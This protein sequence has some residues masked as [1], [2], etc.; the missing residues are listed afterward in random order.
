M[1]E[2]WSSVGGW[3]SLLHSWGVAGRDGCAAN[4]HS[5]VL[6]SCC[7]FYQEFIRFSSDAECKLRCYLQ[8]VCHYPWLRGDFAV[9]LMKLKLPE[10]SYAATC[11][12]ALKWTLASFI[13]IYLSSFLE[14]FKNV[15]NLQSYR[16]W[17]HPFFGPF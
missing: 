17:I 3:R 2:Q 11:S 14:G 8:S 15:L 1:H 5:L 6:D 4:T 16:T 9:M 7:R 13:N 10:T 12:K